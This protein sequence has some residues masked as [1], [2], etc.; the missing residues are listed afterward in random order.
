[1]FILALVL[2]LPLWAQENEPKT[3]WQF[4]PRSIKTNIRTSSSNFLN[5]RQSGIAPGF[6]YV[7]GATPFSR[8]GIGVEQLRWDFDDW[9]EE[10]S[11]FLTV[12]SA[13]HHYFHLSPGKRLQPI[14]DISGYL[15]LG[16]Y[17]VAPLSPNAFPANSF[18]TQMGLQPSLGAMWMQKWGFIEAKVP[19]RL[20]SIE[21][22]YERI[23]N[24]NLP[25]I[26]QQVSVIDVELLNFGSLGNHLAIEIG[27]GF[28]LAKR[29]GD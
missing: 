2:D 26:Q 18:H 13:Y 21:Y 9:D 24:P 20:A 12:R 5:K 17:R 15:E 25:L 11:Q 14:L 22:R 4:Q 1:M 6:E 3:P 7:W 29:Q 23:N 10:R 28:F 27:A 8:Q 19:I 16:R